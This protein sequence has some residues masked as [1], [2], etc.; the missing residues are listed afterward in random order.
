VT[1]EKLPAGDVQLV[2][3]PDDQGGLT[4][5]VEVHNSG[6]SVVRLSGKP[7]V[8]PLGVDGRPLT[9]ECVVTLELRTPGYVDVPGGR[10]ARAPVG[11]AGWDGPPASGQ[12]ELTVSSNSYT[13]VV[14]GPT[15]PAGRGPA[16]N[17]WS[18]WFELLP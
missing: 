2:W 1:D 8:R 4:G 3:S 5:W 10:V 11:W 15:Q 14:D 12:V 9:T 7:G 17:L 13:V 16:T 6:D 18:N